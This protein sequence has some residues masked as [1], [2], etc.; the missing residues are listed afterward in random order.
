MSPSINTILNS[1]TVLFRWDANVNVS[2][3]KLVVGTSQGS[4]DIF[5]QNLGTVT[6]AEVSEI[7]INGESIFVQLKYLIDGQWYFQEYTFKCIL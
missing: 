1:S 4:G 2:E 6:S 5:D 7:P 3:Y